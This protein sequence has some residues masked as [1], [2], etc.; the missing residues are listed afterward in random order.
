MTAISNLFS[1]KQIQ[2]YKES[3]ARINIWEGAVRSGKTFISLWRFIKELQR[4]PEGEYA[5]FVGHTI[6]SSV[7]RF[8]S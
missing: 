8:P 5:L 1:P 4:G 7:I 6:P 3:D 2:S